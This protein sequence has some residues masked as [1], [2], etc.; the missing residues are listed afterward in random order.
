M[1]V[2]SNLK[3]LSKFNKLNFLKKN[4]I[5]SKFC[6]DFNF[7]I[8]PTGKFTI[9]LSDHYINPNSPLYKKPDYIP[10]PNIKRKWKKGKIREKTFIE[11]I[12]YKYWYENPL[13]HPK[14]KRKKNKKD[15]IQ[16]K[17]EFYR[18]PEWET[19]RKKTLKIYGC[20]CMKC[21]TKNMVMHVDHI[22]PRSKYPELALDFNNLQVLCK[23]CNEDKSNTDETD[24]RPN[25]LI[26]LNIE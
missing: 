1:E 7:E 12:K 5:I 23:K 10:K 16:T 17:S 11:T 24:Y 15:K 25:T 2:N 18:T 26:P 6:L 4:E 19:L 9:F 22:K 20:I 21:N 14:N 3:D 8:P 13:N